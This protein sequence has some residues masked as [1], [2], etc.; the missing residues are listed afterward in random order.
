MVRVRQKKAEVA[1]ELNAWNIRRNG[2]LPGNDG[3]V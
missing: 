1:V 2:P 3:K